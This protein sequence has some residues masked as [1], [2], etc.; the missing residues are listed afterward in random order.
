MGQVDRRGFLRMLRRSDKG[1]EEASEEARP[2][3][4]ED[5]EIKQLADLTASLLAD[6]QS[7]DVEELAAGPLLTGPFDRAY[8]RVTQNHIAF[9]FLTGFSSVVKTADVRAL[10]ADP[11]EEVGGY[12]P[13]VVAVLRAQHPADPPG[14]TRAYQ[15]RFKAE[16]PL[17]EAIRTAC[18]LPEP[19]S[20]SDETTEAEAA[21]GE[22]AEADR[23]V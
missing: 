3:P 23:G 7:G 15:F 18:D 11:P 19:E 14:A 21:G 10:D 5:P 20:E 6:F 13:L 2:H 4:P 1:A 9:S 16:D 12:G 17:M 22:P 8:M